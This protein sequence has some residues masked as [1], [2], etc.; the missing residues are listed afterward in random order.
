VYTDCAVTAGCELYTLALPKSALKSI[1]PYD[2]IDSKVMGYMNKFMVNA[3][4]SLLTVHR[5]KNNPGK[6]SSEG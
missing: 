6:S 5:G 1:E 3:Q 4:K 2:F